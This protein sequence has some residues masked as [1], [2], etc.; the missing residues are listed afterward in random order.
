MAAATITTMVFFRGRTL[1]RACRSAAV[2]ALMSG[3]RSA[4][5]IAIARMTTSS[6]A[7]DTSGR[8]FPTWGRGAVMFRATTDCAVPPEKG[9]T[10]ASISYST[11]PRLYWSALAST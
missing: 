10:P 5:S 11:Q 3:K 1:A 6:S 9:A 8:T 7:F 2:M 4:G